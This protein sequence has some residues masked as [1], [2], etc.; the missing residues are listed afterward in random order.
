[1]VQSLTRERPV[2]RVAKGEQTRDRIM[3]I[4]EA[5]VLQKGFAATSIDEILFESGIT[6]SGFSATR[7][8]SPWR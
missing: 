6:K 1:M 2:Q 3:D 7:T 4:A 8:T 5:S